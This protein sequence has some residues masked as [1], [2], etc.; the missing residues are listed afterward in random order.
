MSSV[1]VLRFLGFF[2]LTVTSFCSLGIIF[3]VRLSG[4]ESFSDNLSRLGEMDD[5]V[6]VE[7]AVN[8]IWCINPRSTAIR[9]SE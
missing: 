9:A 4:N 1:N 8:Q 3:H 2:P 5:L 6:H 7:T